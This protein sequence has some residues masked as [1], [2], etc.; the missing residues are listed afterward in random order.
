MEATKDEGGAE[1]LS[2]AV[3]RKFRSPLR[4]TAVCEIWGGGANRTA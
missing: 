2:T 4:E 3:L 1:R